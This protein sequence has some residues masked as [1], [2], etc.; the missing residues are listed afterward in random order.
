[1]IRK[2][3]RA[4]K[5]CV[6]FE[7]DGKAFEAHVGPAALVEEHSVYMAAYPRD[8]GL[9][10]MLKVQAT[11]RGR[12]PC[13]ARFEREGG[14][15]SGDFNTGMGNT[16][17]MVAA[18]V[19]CLDDEPLYDVLA[20]GDNALLFLPPGAVARVVEALPRRALRACGLEL[21]LESP[22]SVL[23]HVRFGQSAPVW[24]GDGWTMVRDYRKVVS[25][26]TSSHRWLREP[27]FRREYLT[28]V[29]LCELSLARGVPVL[30]AYCLH[31]L[32]TLNYRG[33]VRAHPFRDY[34]CMGATLDVD[35][36]P[37][38]IGSEVRNSFER[39]FGLSVEAQ[40]LLETGFNCPLPDGFSRLEGFADAFTAPPLVMDSWYE[41]H[42]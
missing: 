35:R 7:V 41:A 20:D 3:F 37:L 14:R 10:A 42:V 30:Q 12:L 39:A 13:G 4:I 17:V 23:E 36:E 27:S 2:K 9:R 18:V 29:G 15:A 32:D 25:G 5:D 38:P 40:V 21:T 26:A 24:V 31:L 11:L 28:G 19:S 8:K 6:V 16:L 33:R 34:F 22:V 1:L